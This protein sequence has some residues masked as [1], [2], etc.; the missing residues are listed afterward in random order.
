M[1]SAA[2]RFNPLSFCGYQD[3]HTYFPICMHTHFQANLHIQLSL[4][5]THSQNQLSTILQVPIS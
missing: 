4:S 3:G 2:A 1:R 5:I